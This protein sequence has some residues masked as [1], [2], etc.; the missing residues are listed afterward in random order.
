MTTEKIM[1]HI[2]PEPNT[3]CWLWIG[4][5]PGVGYG[6]HRMVYSEL[7]GEIPAGLDIDHKCRVRCCVNPDHLE[8]VTRKENLRRGII[9]TVQ[10]ARH[11]AKTH[12]VHG[13]EFTPENTYTDTRL[14]IVRRTCKTCV[15]D[16]TRK[17]REARRA[18]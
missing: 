12:C 1:E 18:R 16:R 10:H 13:H 5:G 2:S 9:S 15:F 14:G 11:A 4:G 8:P 7:V 17:R 3:G 6:K